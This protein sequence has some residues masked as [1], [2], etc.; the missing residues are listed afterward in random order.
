ML[1]QGNNWFLF[2]FK[3]NFDQVYE[4]LTMNWIKET[5]I[6]EYWIGPFIQLFANV[7]GILHKMIS[8]CTCMASNKF[9]ASF[10]KSCSPSQISAPGGSTEDQFLAS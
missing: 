9:R 6:K 4:I 7:Q 3:G 1:N 5:Y 8:F 2:D 10:V